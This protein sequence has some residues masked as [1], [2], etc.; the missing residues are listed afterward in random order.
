MLIVT[1]FSFS[2]PALAIVNGSELSEVATLAKSV[3]AIQMVE[4]ESSGKINFYKGSGVLISDRVILTAGHNFFYLPDPTLS[5]AIFS[6]KPNWGTDSDGEKRISIKRALVLP[7]FSQGPLG[8]H[9]DLALVQLSESA[10][11]QYRPLKIELWG[12]H[13]PKP[14]DL[15]TILGYGKSNVSETPPLNDFRLRSIDLPFARWDGSSIEDSEKLWVSF[16]RGSFAGGDSGGPV[17]LKR[18]E[19]YWVYGVVIHHRYGKCVTDGTCGDQGAFTNLTFVRN[20]IKSSL[21]ELG[22]VN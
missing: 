2:S 6:V 12:K 4:R 20:W 10:P 15:M 21:H 3:V 7:G 17:L 13:P 16:D 8:T 19:S 22:K 9:H 18:A 11:P 5:S 1:L 14:G